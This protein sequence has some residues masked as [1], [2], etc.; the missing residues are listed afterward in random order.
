MYQTDW[1]PFCR[2]AEALLRRKGVAE[3]EMIDVVLDARGRA[4]L[5]A[6]TGRAS[7]IRCSPPNERRRPGAGST[8]PKGAR[9]SDQQPVFNI[10][11]I[12]VK[13]ASLEAPHAPQI[14]LEPAQPQVEVQLATAA[15]EIGSPSTMT[16][17]RKLTRWGEVYTPTR[18]PASASA[19]ATKV[20]TL[21]FPLV[22]P[23]W[24]VGTT[25]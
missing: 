1:C 10:E 8:T 19:A 11:K 6:R 23:I 22:P 9:V 16:R 18:Q 4:E 21:P 17:S 7:S 12:Y 5:E 25:R 13:D 20:T 15:S 2:R 24:M 3:I 14:F